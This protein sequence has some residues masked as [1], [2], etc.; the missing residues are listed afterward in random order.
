[1]TKNEII[2]NWYR[3]N[4]VQDIVKEVT[5]GSKEEKFK[6]IIQIVYTFLLETPEDKIQQLQ[7]TNQYRYYI[8]KMVMIQVCSNNSRF[9]Y[10]D[11]RFSAQSSEYDLNH[12]APEEKDY[13]QLYELIE[14]LDPEDRQIINDYISVDNKEE[15]A[16]MYGKFP[17]WGHRTV[18]WIVSKLKRIAA[19]EALKAQGEGVMESEEMSASFWKE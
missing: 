1:M 16:K 4:V 14:E 8:A 17:S 11:R 3:N 6:D 15:L 7:E 10:D 5:N 9:H 19:V 2:E 13:S 18:N 12:P